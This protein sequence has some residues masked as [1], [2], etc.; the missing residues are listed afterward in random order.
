VLLTSG[1]TI[2]MLGSAM[3]P[4]ALAFAVLRLTHSTG[5]LGIVLAARSVAVVAFLLVGGVIS[6]RLPRPVVMVGSSVLAGLSESASAALLLTGSAHL[7]ALTA[8][9]VV[10]GATSAFIMPSTS[11]VVPQTVPAEVLRQANALVRMGRNAATIVGA[12]LG[13]VVVAVFGPGWGIAADAASFFVAAVLFAGLQV[14]RVNQGAG[15]SMIRELADGWREFWGRTWL[16]VV[17]VQF[18]F[19]NMA[20]GG[21]FNVLGPVVAEQRLGGAAAWGIIVAAQGAGLIIGGVV[22]AKRHSKRPL[23]AGN[24]A[25][26]LQL[27]MLGLLAVAAPVSLVAA[28]AVLGGIGLE[29]FGVRWVTTMHEQVPATMQSRMFAYDALGSFVFIPVGQALAGPVQS[30][31]GTADAIWASTTVIAV[32]VLAVLF[33]PQVRSLRSRRPPEESRQPGSTTI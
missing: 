21:A 18:S 25:L 27:P 28:A 33:V 6:D 22:S 7:P 2:S 30:L 5:D 3:A 23:L 29:I 20:Y 32:A 12:A 10:N 11:A 17:V 9:Q 13:G 26:L 14:A 4:V 8:L 31:I 1:Q 19:I 24:N 16:W 15:T